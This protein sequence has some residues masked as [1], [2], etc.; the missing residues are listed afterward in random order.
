MPA[1]QRKAERI[2]LGDFHVMAIYSEPHWHE[3]VRSILGRCDGSPF[4][5]AGLNG[6]LFDPVE[7]PDRRTEIIEL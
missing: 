5:I 6:A 3:I 1:F 7:S 4:Q 2:L